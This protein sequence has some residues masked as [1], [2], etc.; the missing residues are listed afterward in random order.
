MRF[1]TKNLP[2]S[3]WIMRDVFHRA[4][5]ERTPSDEL[6]QPDDAGELHEV[7][8]DLKPGFG[9]GFQWTDLPE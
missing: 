9:Y 4:I 8:T 1:D 7:F 6:R 3:A 5:D 2:E